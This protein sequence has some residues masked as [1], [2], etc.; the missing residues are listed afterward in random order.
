MTGLTWYIDKTATG[1]GTGGT[2]GTSQSDKDDAFQTWAAAAVF[3]GIGDKRSDFFVFVS[4][5]SSESSPYRELLTVTGG[6]GTPG[7]PYNI[8]SE[9]PG[10]KT[11]FFNSIGLQQQ[12][13]ENNWEVTASAGG[14]NEFYITGPAGADPSIASP[15]LNHCRWLLSSGFR[16]RA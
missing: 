14:T 5:S 15:P 12:I 6:A 4:G 3:M 1:A 10:E 2:G 16:W 8:R 7:N 9:I 11:V 13:S